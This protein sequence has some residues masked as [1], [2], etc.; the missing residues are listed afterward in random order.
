VIDYRMKRSAMNLT[1]RDVIV[2]TAA[3][4]VVAAAPAQDDLT[5]LFTNRRSAAAIGRAWLA[6]A[7]DADL[8]SLRQT[9]MT[10]L[11]GNDRAPLR[12]R[13]QDRVR[14]D[15]AEGDVVMVEGWMLSSVEA[16][17][18]AIA[19]LSADDYR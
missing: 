5:R 19:W 17:V 12:V 2:L 4:L 3:G 15:F 1:R 14:R 10:A 8:A 7:P 11:R 9:V 18:C 16:R 6:E 13:F